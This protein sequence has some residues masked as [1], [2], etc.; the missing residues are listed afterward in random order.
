MKE[1]QVEKQ[2]EHQSHKFVIP[3]LHVKLVILDILAIIDT[4]V[5]QT[6]L[7]FQTLDIR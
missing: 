2:T 4:I 7:F 5:A 3:C 1:K 6:T